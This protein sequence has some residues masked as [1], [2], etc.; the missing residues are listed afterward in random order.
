MAGAIRK[1]LKGNL[2]FRRTYV[3]S[4]R[5]FLHRL[6][7]EGQSPDTL[8][9]GCSDSRVIPELLTG[10]APGELF[11]VRNIA[12]VVPPVRRRGGGVGAAIEYALEALAVDHMVVCGHYGCGGVRAAVEGIH[13]DPPLPT[14]ER[15]LENVRPAARRAA[16]ALRPGEA[17]LRRAVEENV[18]EQL[19]NL[20]TYPA[21]R[22]ALDAG[23]LVLHGWCFE[24]DT[25][26]VLVWDADEDV[27]LPADTHLTG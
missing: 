25:G 17:L 6:V 19:A 15:W 9:I 12:N 13:H 5:E 3:S 22:A 11:V 27:F 24:M 16:R 7:S 18:E 10:S 4:Q 1:L 21:V 26:R 14:V 8:F 20:A 2:E 23:K